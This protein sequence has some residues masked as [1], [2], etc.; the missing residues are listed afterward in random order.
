MVTLRISSPTLLAVACLLT[1]LWPALAQQA[2]TVPTP[3]DEATR[4]WLLFEQVSPEARVAALKH[5]H[6]HYPGFTAD[7][8][9]LVAS[10]HPGFI[11]ELDTQLA[12]LMGSSHLR[13]ALFIQDQ[14]AETIQTRYPQVNEALAQLVREKYPSLLDD[15]AGIPPGPQR[16]ATIRTLVRAKY[17]ALAADVLLL[18]HQ[19]VPAVLTELQEA[20]MV[21]FP[22]LVSD[23]M[24]LVR[25]KHPELLTAVI[26]LLEAHRPGLMAEL[27]DILSSTPPPPDAPVEQPQPKE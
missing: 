18:L 3:D 23:L 9:A 27:V 6:Q 15:L 14:V 5:L 25:Q 16:A 11:A 22:T 4:C 20:V 10:R 7:V 1:A 17:P 2:E 24:G 26:G 19:Q 8:L 13:V 21:R 12:Q